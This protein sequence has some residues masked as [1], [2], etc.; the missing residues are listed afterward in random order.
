[1]PLVLAFCRVEIFESYL[2]DDEVLAAL[3]EQ[4]GKKADLPAVIAA[5]NSAITSSIGRGNP[6]DDLKKA[7]GDIF[8]STRHILNL[9]GRGNDPRAFARATLAPLVK[10]GIA[11]YS[12]LRQA[13]FGK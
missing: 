4:E 11:L 8:N 13:I 5:R 12:E 7:A 3:R 6:S 1:M 2:F 9:V 10:P